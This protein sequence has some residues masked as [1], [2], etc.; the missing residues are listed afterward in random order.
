MTLMTSSCYLRDVP[1]RAT[2]RSRALRAGGTIDDVAESASQRVNFT[3]HLASP[4]RAVTRSNSIHDHPTSAIGRPS[5]EV[6]SS[7][8]AARGLEDLAGL[9]A[10][11]ICR[12]LHCFRQIYRNL[13]AVVAAL[14]VQGDVH[15]GDQHWHFHERADH[16]GEGHLGLDSEDRDRYCNGKLK[17][18]ARG[19]ERNTVERE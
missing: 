17:V 6:C 19:G 5:I 15:Q 2:P 11:F 9:A 1:S 13:A 14:E 4:K 16:R 10:S 12:V 18:V 7:L 8:A 3:P